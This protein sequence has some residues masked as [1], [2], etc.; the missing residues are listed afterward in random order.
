MTNKCVGFQ[1]G[2][3]EVRN[4]DPPSFFLAPVLK[5]WPREAVMLLGLFLPHHAL[6]SFR[7]HHDALQGP[8]CE[9]LSSV[10]LWRG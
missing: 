9:E 2:D 8:R 1:K 6:C 3:V 10:L 5:P 7:E 4:A